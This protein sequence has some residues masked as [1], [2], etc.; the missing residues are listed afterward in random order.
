MNK[1][2][3]AENTFTENTFTLREPVS[4]LTHF[5]GFWL[6]LIAMPMLFMRASMSPVVN[7]RGEFLSLA[8]FALSMILLYAASS[9]YHSFILSERSIKRLKKIDHLMIFVLIAGTYTPMCTLVL[10]GSM[11]LILLYVIW[12]I[13]AAGMIFKLFWV[14]CPKWI[15]SVMYIA[16]GWTAIFF[17][18]PLFRILSPSQFTLLLLGGILYTVGGVI[19]ALKW[20]LSD[21]FGSHE[22]FH[23]FVMLGSLC[24]YV[25]IYSIL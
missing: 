12:G 7:T 2:I 4:A 1:A 15:S 24:H 10:R 9:A 11:G 18:I 6:S 13:A 20:K 17:I 21:A 16:M 14:T 8:V 3:T 22:L 5:A 25:M 23:V 19:Y